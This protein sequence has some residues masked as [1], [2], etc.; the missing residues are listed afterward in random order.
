MQMVLPNQ[1]PYLSTHLVKAGAQMSLHNHHKTISQKRY[2]YTRPSTCSSSEGH[3]S[4]TQSML[5]PPE[6]HL[7]MMMSLVTVYH[8]ISSEQPTAPQY[9]PSAKLCTDYCALSK[10]RTEGSY[11]YAWS[12]R[13]PEFLK[14]AS[15]HSSCRCLPMR[16]LKPPVAPHRPCEIFESYLL[17]A[18]CQRA[19]HIPAVNRHA[20]SGA[21]NSHTRKPLVDLSKKDLKPFW[22]GGF[23]TFLGHNPNGNWIDLFLDL[24][25][26]SK[27][28]VAFGDSLKLS[29]PPTAKVA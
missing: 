10:F 3:T 13:P 6:E 20:Y 26:H 19:A 28:I 27:D 21:I 24:K 16:S 8:L 2:T 15:C 4:H 11:A 14:L 1:L 29:T 5:T 23:W 25:H 9:P 22:L 18:F 7:N 12:I 17:Y